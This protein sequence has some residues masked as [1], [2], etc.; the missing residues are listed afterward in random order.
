M[1]E[2]GP[3]P[4]SGGGRMTLVDLLN[5]AAG[6]G[7]TPS[8]GSVPSAPLMQ[9][10][11]KAPVPQFV[12][13]WQPDVTAWGYGGRGDVSNPSPGP[14]PG[15][16]PA[17]APGQSPAPVAAEPLAPESVLGEFA[18]GFDKVGIDVSR[19][20]LSPA[21]GLPSLPDFNPVP[22]API[23]APRANPLG[24]TNLGMRALGL[25]MPSSSPSPSVPSPSFAEPG[26]PNVGAPSFSTP[27][28]DVGTGV[29]STGKFGIPEPPALREPLQDMS[30][31]TRAWSPTVTL[32]I[33]MPATIGS[34]YSMDPQYNQMTPAEAIGM[35]FGRGAGGGGGGGAQ[36]QASTD[37]TSGGTGGS[38]VAPGDP[39]GTG[40]PGIF[41]RGGYTGDDGRPGDSVRGKVHEREYVH[42]SQTT[43]LVGRKFLDQMR[44]IGRDRK[45]S[46]KQKKDA[47][48]KLFASWKG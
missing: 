42:D 21:A 43:A 31:A 3:D 12:P 46:T 9:S 30:W 28:R 18:P 5:M 11:A 10:A 23:S 41:R 8:I 40:A 17:A 14:S 2:F 45:M 33:D 44:R 34:Y 36:N 19:G 22:S 6:Y 24:L 35:G 16:A 7:S 25:S 4:Y 1:P 15:P 37:H 47:M 32:G 48:R 26:H 38:G 27:S 13:A 29:A 20:G 39:Q